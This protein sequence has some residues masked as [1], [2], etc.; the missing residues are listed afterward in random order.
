MLHRYH[1]ISPLLF[2]LYLMAV[3]SGLTASVRAEPVALF[4]EEFESPTQ[5]MARWKW[6]AGTGEVAFAPGVVYLRGGKQDFP[7]LTLRSNPFPKTGAFTVTV[8]FRYSEIKARGAGITVCGRES[9]VPLMS[10]FQEDREAKLTLLLNNKRVWQTG[11]D[12]EWHLLSLAFSETGEVEAFWDT[13][14]VGCSKSAVRPDFLGIGG[15]ESSVTG[16]WSRLAVQGVQIAGE[17][18]RSGVCE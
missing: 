4:T 11:I 15:N 16:E 9:S 13:D 6:D 18:K 17:W 3:V 14:S 10:L 8:A 2:A 7:A 1:K 5:A 12:E